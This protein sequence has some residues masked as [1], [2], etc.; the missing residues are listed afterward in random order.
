MKSS[1]LVMSFVAVLLITSA[2]GSEEPS[3]APPERTPFPVCTRTIPSLTDQPVTESLFRAADDELSEM[4]DLA[5]AGDV[6]G[7]QVA[8][9]EPHNL[10][11]NVDE[12]LR[13]MDEA[14]AIRLCNEVVIIEEE[15][16]GNR[17][18]SVVAEQARKIREILS[19]I[20]AALDMEPE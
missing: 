14:L 16:V 12:P 4:I 10:T 1:L 17:D 9:F 20:A 7:A 15:L 13:R 19:D 8:F 2:C 6:N 5:E 3:A 11:H 18:S